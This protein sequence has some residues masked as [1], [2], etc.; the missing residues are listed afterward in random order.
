MPVQKG[1]KGM[2]QCMG[3][4]K[5]GSLHHGGSGEVV[6]RRDVAQAICLR[7][8]GQSKPPSTG[9]AKK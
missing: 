9:K 1:P 8:S 4:Y 5:R 2:E 3:E 7:L 6:K